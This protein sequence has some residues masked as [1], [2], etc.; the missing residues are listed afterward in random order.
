LI[1]G[2]DKKDNETI[3]KNLSKYQHPVERKKIF[4]KISLAKVQR[5]LIKTGIKKYVEGAHDDL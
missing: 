3:R 1:L 4:N 2:I 5:E